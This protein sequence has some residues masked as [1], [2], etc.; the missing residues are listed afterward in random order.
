[1][2]QYR[3]NDISLPVALQNAG[4]GDLIMTW[5]FEIYLLY[6]WFYECLGN[7][8]FLSVE[9][10]FEFR[11][12][13]TRVEFLGYHITFNVKS[14]SAHH[15]HLVIFD[16]Q[17]TQAGGPYHLEVASRREGGRKERGEVARCSAEVRE[18]SVESI[19]LLI[20]FFPLPEEG[21]ESSAGV[22]FGKLCILHQK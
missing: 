2:V 4:S 13:Q 17:T 12:W 14:P 19:K 20:L 21:G 5:Q 9:S 18:E 10:S 1:M 8:C 11:I 6:K 15:P 3:M 7:V 16:S 22:N